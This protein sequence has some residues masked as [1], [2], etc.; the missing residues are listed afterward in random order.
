[1]RDYV[2]VCVEKVEEML[3]LGEKEDYEGEDESED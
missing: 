2:A 1:V 3:E